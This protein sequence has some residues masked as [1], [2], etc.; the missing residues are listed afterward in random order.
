MFSAAPG[1]SVLYKCPQMCQH[2]APIN[3]GYLP[4]CPLCLANKSV[5]DSDV[6]ILVGLSAL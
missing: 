5:S 3:Q 4:V 1:V 2:S 6:E